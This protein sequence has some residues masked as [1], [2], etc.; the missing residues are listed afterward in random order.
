MKRLKR[1]L[2]ILA[3]NCLLL[4]VG[5]T[6]VEVIFGGWLDT[7]KL[8]R[9]NLLKDCVLQY[10]VSNL[11]ND[12][13]PIIQYSRDKYGLRGTYGSPGNIKILTIGGSTTDQRYI[14][15]GETWQDV[16]QER[17]RQTGVTLAV[18]NAGVDGQSTYGHIKNFEWWFSNIP[19]LKPD[20]ILS[21]VGL[22]DF[23]KEAGYR[24]DRLESAD[25]IFSLKREVKENIALWHMVRTLR[26]A[27]EVMVVKKIGHRS[28]S[29]SEVDW[30]RDPL[31]KD[32]GFMDSRLNEYASRLRI[33]ADMTY[34]LG[35]KPIFVSQI[36]RK[37]R[38]TP[39][40]IVGHSNI[41]SYDGYQINGVDYYH[42]MRRLD[43]VTE[44]VAREK[45][46]FFVDLARH[47]GWIDT[48][49]YDFAHMT[50]QGAHKVADLLYDALRNIYAGAEQI[51]SPARNS[52][53]LRS[54]PFLAGEHDVRSL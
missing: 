10:D 5:L 19:D 25:Q 36:S 3:V 15:D 37:Y 47:N 50:P 29:F 27:Y 48:D 52:A 1:I 12:L 41:S 20:Y 6:I 22:N 35:A 53:P 24:Y 45:N 42:M 40:G 13:N 18:A 51:A 30:T 32:Y 23:H 49:F 4:A 39:D 2:A 14:R 16:L 26:G 11:Y 46:A 38:I 9:L 28:I 33:L 17:F 54:A 34:D 44:A 31:Q 7:R 43:R 8:N 21:Y